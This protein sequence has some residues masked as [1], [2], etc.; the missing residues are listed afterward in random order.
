MNYPYDLV[1]ICIYTIIISVLKYFVIFDMSVT[2]DKISC[3]IV[4]Y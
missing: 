1:Y 4:K 3:M 2:V